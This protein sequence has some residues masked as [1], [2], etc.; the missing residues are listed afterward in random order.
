MRRVRFTYRLFSAPCHTAAAIVKLGQLT[1][2]NLV[3]RGIR[4]RRLPRELRRENEYGVI[5]AVD[6]A[7]MSTT[8]DHR[9]A[10]GYAAQGGAGLVFEIQMGMVDRGA[11]ISWLS[12]YIT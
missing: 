6:F 9:V 5:G 12:Q 2:A 11:D 7:F 3:Y 1:R 10:Q 4:E 8:L